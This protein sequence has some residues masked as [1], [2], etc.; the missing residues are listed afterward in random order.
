MMLAEY[1][2]HDL[3][4]KRLREN[5]SIENRGDLK[6]ELGKSKI[7]QVLLDMDFPVLYTTNYDHLIESYYEM[8]GH[9]FSKVTNIANMGNTDPASTR[10]MKFH[11]DID[12]KK[13]IVLLESHYFN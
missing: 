5:L 2:E 1:L 7:Y 6:K 9:K 10:I 12:D 3:V 4:Y 8:K 11:G 13:S